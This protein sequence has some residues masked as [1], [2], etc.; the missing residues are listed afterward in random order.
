MM[1]SQ[2]GA[3]TTYIMQADCYSPHDSC[4][5]SLDTDTNLGFFSLKMQT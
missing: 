2:T 4:L 1:Q 3:D 5:M